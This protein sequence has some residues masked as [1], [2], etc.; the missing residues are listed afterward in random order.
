MLVSNKNNEKFHSIISV[1]SS[2]TFQL[3]CGK[4][5]F[6]GIRISIFFNQGETGIQW[7]ANPMSFGKHIHLCNQHSSQNIKV[8]IP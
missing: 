1:E 4:E 5:D 6:K 7:N 8:P 2:S 3:K